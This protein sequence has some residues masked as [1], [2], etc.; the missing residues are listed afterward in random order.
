MFRGFQPARPMR[1]GN[2]GRNAQQD[3]CF[4]PARSIREDSVDRNAQ[5]DRMSQAEPSINWR[6][7]DQAVTTVRPRFP[8]RPGGTVDAAMPNGDSPRRLGMSMSP[9]YLG[10]PTV[11]SN[12]SAAI[13]DSENTS[14]WVTGFP[15]ES[16]TYSTLVDM[17]TG[18]G[19]IRAL[20]IAN[21]GSS[22][23]TAAASITYFRH[24]D[25]V[26]A[27]Q[28][29]NDGTLRAPSGRAAARWSAQQNGGIHDDLLGPEWEDPT[30]IDF[31]P[32]GTPRGLASSRHRRPE[33]VRLRACWNRV[34]VAEW[35]PL[36]DNGSGFSKLP[37]RVI[38]VR[39]LPEVVGPASMKVFFDENFRYNLDRVLYRGTT[40]GL[41]EYEYRFACW[42]NQAE[43][44]IMAIRREKFDV[45]IWYGTDPCEAKKKKAHILDT[46]DS[47]TQID[48]PVLAA[49]KLGRGLEAKSG[50]WN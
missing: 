32:V 4:Q 33:S 10:D 46:D 11:A 1:E 23:R 22:W 3:L 20:H 34:R 2:V 26:N 5:Q 47:D 31:G 39:G 41:E 45:E 15:P 25:A 24:T 6:E 17:L 16:A 35:T 49:Q 48:V 37:S 13:T 18:R 44:A 42:K 38:R 40:K 14:I 30:L 9:N 36:H 27:M 12:H 29:F 28:A 7:P 8:M 43:F 50:W 21:D 19:K